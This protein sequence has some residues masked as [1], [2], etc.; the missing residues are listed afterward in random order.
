MEFLLRNK[1]KI[2]SETLI[3]DSLSELDESKM[4]N[5]VNVYIYRLRNKI[6]KGFDTKLIKTVRGMGF[7]LSEKDDY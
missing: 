2:L 4:S 1:E 5:I 6:D 7:V 3:N